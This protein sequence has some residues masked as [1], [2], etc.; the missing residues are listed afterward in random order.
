[1]SKK[2][3]KAKN[4]VEIRTRV[5]IGLHERVTSYHNTLPRKVK[6]EDTIA[7]AI[8]YGMDKLSPT[9]PINI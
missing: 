7:I 3:R 4:T 2:I 8:E 6:L 9:A 1:M 5:N